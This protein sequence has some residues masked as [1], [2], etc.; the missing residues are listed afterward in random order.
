MTD[1]TEKV[2]VILMAIGVSGVG[3]TCLM[4]AWKMFEYFWSIK[5]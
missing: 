5:Q 3:V 1:S 4:L 2:L